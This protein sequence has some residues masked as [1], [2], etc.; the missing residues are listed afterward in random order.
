M[1]LKKKET[2]SHF[3]QNAK[4]FVLMSQTTQLRR[5]ILPARRLPEV[6]KQIFGTSARRRR[7]LRSLLWIANDPFA[8]EAQ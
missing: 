1:T 6:R 8:A 5:E 7:I 3:R 2:Y 4:L